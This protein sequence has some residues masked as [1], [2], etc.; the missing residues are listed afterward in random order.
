MKYQAIIGLEIHVQLSTQSKMFCSCDNAGEDKKPNTTICPICTGQPGTLPVI[1]QKAVDWAVM[2]ALAL[3]GQI[4]EKSHFDRKSYF[5]PDLPKGYQISQY[6]EPIGKGGFLQI[7]L[8]GEKRKIRLERLHLEEDTGK[9][10]HQKEKTLVDFNRAGSPLMEIV[11][12]PDIKSP[13]EARIFLQELRLIMRYLG[14]SD[15]DMEKGHMRCDANISLR[16]EGD[17]KLYPKT[18]IKNLNSFKSVEKALS[19]EIKRQTS[20]WDEKKAPKN[21]STRGWDDKKQV[22][23]LQR[24]KEAV[25]DYRY[26]PEPDLP[27]LE[28]TDKYLNKIKSKMPE[29]PTDKRKRFSEKFFFKDK[30]IKII[31]SDLDLAGY[32]ECIITELKN[33][34]QAESSTDEGLYQWEQNKEKFS[35]LVANWLINRLLALMHESNVKVKDLKITPE[36]FAE[37]IK[38]VYNQRVNKHGANKV[39]EEMFK[40]GGDPSNIIEEK[41]LGTIEDEDKLSSVIDEVIE[42]NQSAVQ[43][44]LNGKEAALK[45]LLGQVMKKTKGQ[46][47]HKVVRQLLIHKLK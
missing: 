8:R 31:V 38:I 6:S 11:T 28:F 36:N 41:N 10:I 45:F 19:Y 37:F 14:V 24:I 29:M 30:D 7:K 20:L 39:L 13:E 9:L 18:E 35:H 34:L 22:T 3:Q 44:Y 4:S 23:I 15:A 32:T 43:E 1:N 40:T 42:E 17:K 21:Q 12:E 33:W 26:F 46:A 47:D 16:F 25:H 2:S 5:Y 27:P